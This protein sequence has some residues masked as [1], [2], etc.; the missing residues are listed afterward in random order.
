MSAEIKKRLLLCNVLTT[1]LS[2]A[3]DNNKKDLKSLRQ[4]ISEKILKKILK[5]LFPM[6]HYFIIGLTH[7]HHSIVMNIYSILFCN[8]SRY[9]ILKPRGVTLK[10][11]T[12]KVLTMDWELL[13][14]ESLTMPLNSAS[15]SFKMPLTSFHGLT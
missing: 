11:F 10:R 2:V 14:K 8:T 13:Q 4:L 9:L 5:K 7:H 15:I 3:V 6:C 1:K 12:V